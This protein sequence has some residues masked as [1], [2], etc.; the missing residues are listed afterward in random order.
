MSADDGRLQKSPDFWPGKK[1]KKTSS[2]DFS[3]E[4]NGLPPIELC[5]AS[6]FLVVEL[7]QA[8]V[9]LVFELCQAPV[10]GEKLSTK[11]PT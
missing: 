6:V 9:F 3:P 10:F 7:C 5:L 4:E 2:G 11:Y 8:P 1:K